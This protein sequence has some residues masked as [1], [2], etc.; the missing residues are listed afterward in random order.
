MG[1]ST[2]EGPILAADQRFGPQRDAGNVLLTQSIFLDYSKTTNQAAG[3]AGGSGVFATSNTIPNSVATIWAPQS[4]VFSN[5]GPSVTSNTPTADASGTNYRGCVFLL[6]Q[7]S[8]LQNI[9]FDN[10]VQPTDGTNA[11]TAIQPYISNDFATSAGVYATS[12]S[13]TGSSIG[14]T[15][16][17][18]TATQYGNAQAMLQDVQNIQPG[19]QPTWF[20]QLVITLKLTVASLTSVNAGKMNIIVQYVLPDTN[21]GNGTTYPYGNFD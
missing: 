8:Y 11:V 19:Q 5:T 2:F 3:Y 17:T 12:G 10:I 20:S 6:P 4:G 13:I 16:A 9:Y 1:R 15:T 21:I 7:G 18:F 14:R